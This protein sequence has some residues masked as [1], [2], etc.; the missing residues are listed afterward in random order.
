MIRRGSTI[1]FVLVISAFLAVSLLTLLYI[2]ALSFQ[3]SD[4]FITESQAYL[5][6]RNRVLPHYKDYL[7]DR[8]WAIEE[9]ISGEDFIDFTMEGFRAGE[10]YRSR[11][12][13]I[14]YNSVIPFVWNPLLQKDYIIA[15][16]W[17][18]RVDN[19]IMY[20]LPP[21]H[22]D[23]NMSYYDSFLFYPPPGIVDYAPEFFRARQRINK[24][25]L[26]KEMKSYIYPEENNNL[27]FSLEARNSNEI[28]FFAIPDEQGVRELVR[29]DSSVQEKLD[30]NT[31]ELIPGE[32]IYENM[33]YE[34]LRER[35]PEA[36]DFE[37]IQFLLNLHDSRCSNEGP[38]VVFR[39]TG[40]ILSNEAALKG[41]AYQERAALMIGWS[42]NPVINEV[43]A[44]PGPG[45]SEGQY[46]EIF[47]PFE[48]EFDITGWSI[49]VYHVTNVNAPVPTYIL[50]DEFVVSDRT[51][52]PGDF[53][54]VT[55][56]YDDGSDSFFG[57]LNVF[58][59]PDKYE[60]IQDL[61][62]PLNNGRIEIWDNQER[63]VDYFEYRG[64]IGENFNNNQSCN[65]YYPLTRCTDYGSKKWATYYDVPS[66]GKE[67]TPPVMIFPNIDS[68]L[69]QGQ[70]PRTR[71]PL[72]REFFN[73]AELLLVPTVGY[74]G[75]FEVM[76]GE[77]QKYFSPFV[78]MEHADYKGLTVSVLDLFTI[79]LV[80]DEKGNPLGRI[81]INTASQEALYGLTDNAEFALYME[82]FRENTPEYY[83]AF[84]SFGE[85]F[86]NVFIWGE[87]E[88][89][90]IPF[91]MSSQIEE[92]SRFADFIAFTSDDYWVQIELKHF[93]EA[94]SLQ[95]A[96]APE[97]QVTLETGQQEW[98]SD[99]SYL[100]RVQ[101]NAS[102]M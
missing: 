38:T 76:Q 16:P 67:N 44:Y 99:F 6:S 90:W 27:M 49:V 37:L 91:V 55:D 92:F 20:I 100:F 65:R 31:L 84:L 18:E 3:T 64:M 61:A 9:Q 69:E 98:E 22:P 72:N 11:V 14:D 13:A 46:L 2:I 59:E 7:F 86:R 34:L 95:Q 70:T 102:E 87:P 19:A 52:Q 81:N 63:L 66:P 75:E 21:D 62:L 53:L 97:E 10:L 15:F 56:N 30:I 24:A 101:R 71:P 73:L 8:Q 25:V 48:E 79:D 85:L 32:I 88:A 68:L 60:E 23:A 36:R 51:L 28:P 33:F 29:N 96:E 54:V 80:S 78:L 12:E 74:T 57:H 58:L 40:E 41:S 89:V 39:P 1:I 45:N 17:Y 43:W 94:I 42:R 35:F 4:D 93:M 82:E 47:N 5:I 50:I 77:S 26:P 83:P